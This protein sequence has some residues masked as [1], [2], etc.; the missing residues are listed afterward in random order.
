VSEGAVAMRI[1]I[2]NVSR[3]FPQVLAALA[4]NR[5]TLSVAALLAPHLQEDNIDELL[6]DCT[7]MTKRKAEVRERVFARANHQCEFESE[8]GTRCSSR[9]GLEIEHTRPFGLF[10]DNDE[11]WLAALCPSHN[12]FMAER[13]YGADFIQSKID[14]RRRAME[15]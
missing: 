15:S 7:G 13:V 9:T 11:R 4:E 3:R 10:R 5:I 8:D 6:S 12:D 1:Q 14:E 2:A